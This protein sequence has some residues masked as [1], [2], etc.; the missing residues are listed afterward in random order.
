VPAELSYN[1]SNPFQTRYSLPAIGERRL[2]GRANEPLMEQLMLKLRGQ[3]SLVK[4]AYQESLDL[5]RIQEK[6][7]RGAHPHGR[8]TEDFSW[9]KDRTILLLGD[10]IDR[11]HLRA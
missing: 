8:K 6:G 10:S 2:A 11:Y 4:S 3:E 7:R 1:A 5:E 9:L